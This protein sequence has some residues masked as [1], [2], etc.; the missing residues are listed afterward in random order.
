MA[1]LKLHS[2]TTRSGSFSIEKKHYENVGLNERL[3]SMLLGG[4]L[5]GSTLKNPFKSRFLYGAYLAYRGLTG[6]CYLYDY[7]GIDSKRPHAVNIRGEFEIDLPPAQ[8]Y[9]YWRNLNNLPVSLS[10]MLNVDIKDEKLSSWRANIFNNLFSLKW[11]AEIVK[12]ELNHLIG[13]RAAKGSA[14]RHVGRVEFEELPY[15]NGT[16]LKIALSYHPPGG[17]VGQGVSKILTPL[18]ENLLKKEIKNFKYNIEH[19]TPMFI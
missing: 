19:K 8:V 5:I 9:S 12:D 11:D 13:W 14:F 18:L 10:Q 17:G 1:A 7:L 3:F 6:K 15:G 2:Q 4:V 16:L